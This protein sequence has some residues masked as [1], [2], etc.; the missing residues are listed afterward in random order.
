MS[1]NNLD[2]ASSLAKAVDTVFDL[3]VIGGGITGCGIALDASARGMKTLLVEKSDYA[4]GTSSKSTKLIHGGL[5]YLKQL[6]FGLVRETGVERAVVHN[7]APH[8]VHPEKMFLP[9]VD[10]GTFGKMSAS[11]AI[12]VYDFLAKVE[13]EDQK[14]SID[15]DEAIE[16]EPLVKSDF[17]NG[18]IIYSEYRTD[19]ARL[20]IELMKKAEELGCECFN[21]LEM[22]KGIYGSDG[23]ITGITCK[24]NQSGNEFEFT[25]KAVVSAAG[26]WVDGIRKN[27]GSFAG[28][29]LYLTKGV[30]IVID[31][32]K[33]NLNQAVYF[34]DFS[35]RMLFAIPRGR[36]TYIGTTD[37]T[38]EENLDRVI[39]N[40][41]D[42][43]YIL[44]AVNHFFD[45]APL[46]LADVDSTWAGL[47]PLIHQEGKSPTELSR[48]DEIFDSPTGLISIAGG[49]LTGY[50]KMAERIVDLVAKK[51]P[52][53]SDSD[54]STEKLVLT[55]KAFANYDEVKYFIERFGKE[56]VE[57]NLDTYYSWYLIS[58]YGKDAKQI[59][60]AMVLSDEEDKEKALLLAEL[61]Y[62]IKNEGLLHPLDLLQR[63]T[64]RL[65]FDID[66]VQKYHESVV[67]ACANIFEVDVMTKTNW[68]N[69]IEAAIGDSVSFKVD[70]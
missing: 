2:R 20:T 24:D 50:R 4:S 36:I 13:Q 31:R 68:N 49:K 57:A 14:E 8:L 26:P 34:D 66:S 48:K 59:F 64:G 27:D 63:R 35:G 30:H 17:L 1:L 61:D 58:T 29:K 40:R 18:G 55:R 37:T 38:Y 12:S 43:E 53:F 6:E 28:S 69:E 15:K 16:V 45:I 22:L 46:G 47:R 21:Y 54:C 33:L 5:R 56:V 51:L 62:C 70:D 11:L 10:N 67:D 52:V 25:A 42:V 7:L 44:N 9:I 32:E 23:K 60:D 39:A 41:E 65:Y 3:I 19:D